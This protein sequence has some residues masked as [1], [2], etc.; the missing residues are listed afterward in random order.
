MLNIIS[1]NIFHILF[2]A[3]KTPI[4]RLI[5]QHVIGKYAAYWDDIG[6]ILGVENLYVIRLDNKGECQA[7]FKDTLTKWLQIDINASWEKLQNAI[8]QAITNVHGSMPKDK[9]G[10]LYKVLFY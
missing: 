8:N 3:K 1:L 2:I 5:N 10:M 6:Q 4:M 7:C 9:T